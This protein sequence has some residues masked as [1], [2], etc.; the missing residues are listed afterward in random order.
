MQNIQVPKTDRQSAQS[1][2]VKK[3]KQ[4]KTKKKQS[5]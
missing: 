2:T 5:V 1:T 4:I 3:R